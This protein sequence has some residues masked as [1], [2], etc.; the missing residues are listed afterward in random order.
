MYSTPSGSNCWTDSA[1]VSKLPVADLEGEQPSQVFFDKMR[2]GEFCSASDMNL[3]NGFNFPC[4]W[5][6][7]DPI[8][9]FLFK[10]SMLHRV[11]PSYVAPAG[12]G[13][14]SCLRPPEK[15]GLRKGVR[16]PSSF[17]ALSGGKRSISGI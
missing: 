2:A 5:I 13:W 9:Q 10:N 1:I 11:D 7:N 16:K 12:K 15:R 3:D 17:H 8:F 6:W 4:I 14:C